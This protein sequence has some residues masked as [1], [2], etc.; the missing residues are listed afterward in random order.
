MKQFFCLG[1][2]IFLWHCSCERISLSS[3]IIVWGIKR[4]FCS[5]IALR[6]SHF[7]TRRLNCLS[8]LSVWDSSNLSN[9]S[10][11]SCCSCKQESIPLGCV[12]PACQ[13]YVFWWPLLGGNTSGCR[14][15]MGTISISLVLLWDKKTE[16]FWSF[17]QSK[18]PPFYAVLQTSLK[19]RCI[20]LK[21]M[22]LY[23]VNTCQMVKLKQFF[24]LGENIFLMD[25]VSCERISLSSVIIV[26]FSLRN[27]TS[28]LL[29]DV[30]FA[31]A[32]SQPIGLFVS[33][34][35][36]C[37]RYASQWHDDWL[38]SLNGKLSHCDGVKCIVSWNF[39]WIFIKN[40]VL[41]FPERGSCL[42]GIF[43][44]LKCV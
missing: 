17:M 33:L 31:E 2:N 22:S 7:S 18:F 26:R 32:I 25:T 27:K 36:V 14:K 11:M 21:Q 24:C 13:P 3:V 19:F 38:L 35:P 15:W 34:V 16:S 1:E 39:T 12:A 4:Q 37:I 28:I 30:P 8:S 23:W 6:R 20:I 41:K 5:L 9:L 42:N 40:V 10:N 29:I 44:L 43:C